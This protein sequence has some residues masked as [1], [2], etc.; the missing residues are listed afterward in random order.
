MRLWKVIGVSFLALTMLGG[1][2][3]T[4]GTGNGAV[5]TADVAYA[6]SLQLTN[7][8][9]LAPSFTQSTGFKYRGYGNGATAIANLI[10][11]GEITPN[12][13]ES[14][15]TAPLKD[16]GRDKVAYGIG[17]AGS[18]L[19]IAYSNKSPYAKQ[20]RA[21]A[22]GQKPLKTLFPLM[23]QPNFH[24][25]RTD[26]NADP[27]GQ[28]FV[29]MMNLAEKELHLPKGTSARI[30][31][32]LSNPKQVYSETD[33][34]SRLQAGQMDASS[35]YL[36]EAVQQGLPYIQLPAAVNLGDPKYKS[37]YATEHLKLS[38]GQTVTGAP[39]ELYITGV[40]GSPDHQAGT[41]FIH[42]ALSKPGLHIFKQNGYTLTPMTVWGKR[43]KIPGSI[44]PEL[45]GSQ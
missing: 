10:R 26:P 36:P 15:G 4:T 35:A 31:G 20:L 12:V 24:L 16:A 33:I 21:I 8:K 38:N 41:A 17:F 14:I 37:R 13:F 42:F 28:Y 5:G 39:I 1:C 45:K 7:D 44:L 40:Q 43:S 29:M 9:G 2:A 34:L 6:G 25:G 3:P 30:L 22:D 18:P 11:S 27:Q 19:V 23:E 32:S